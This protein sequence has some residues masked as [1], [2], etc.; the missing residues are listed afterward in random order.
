[1]GRLS[2]LSC[3]YQQARSRI[4]TV[5]TTP[6]LHLRLVELLH[7][8][9][10]L[11]LPR[12][13]TQDVQPK[14]PDPQSSLTSPPDCVP[15]FCSHTTSVSFQ[16]P[17]SQNMLHISSTYR[18]PKHT[19]GTPYIQSTNMQHSTQQCII[20]KQTYKDNI[21]LLLRPMVAIT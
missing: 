5:S 9:L 6:L 7:P 4:D 11:Q 21:H 2:D 16:R 13:N 3:I 15:W 18:W 8:H 20:C 14:L 12:S 19:A 17:V 10:Q 1:M